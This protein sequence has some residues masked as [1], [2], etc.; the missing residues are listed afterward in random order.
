LDRLITKN[1]NGI[2][3]QIYASLI[4]YLILQL[5]SVPKEWGEKMLDKFRYLQACM[6]QQISYVHGRYHEMLTFSPLIGLP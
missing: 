2:A 4:A 3:I 5:V 1:V 6:C